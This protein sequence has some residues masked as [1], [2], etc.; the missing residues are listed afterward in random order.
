MTGTNA[1]VEKVLVLDPSRWQGKN[2]HVIHLLL[3]EN[4]NEIRNDFWF[5]SSFTWECRSSWALL[6]HRKYKVKVVMRV[7]ATDKCQGEHLLA[8]LKLVKKLIALFCVFFCFCFAERLFSGWFVSAHQSLVGT[9]YGGQRSS[10][11]FCGAIIPPNQSGWI[12]SQTTWKRVIHSICPPPTIK[13]ERRKSPLTINTHWY[14]YISFSTSFS[15][16]FEGSVDDTV[17]IRVDGSPII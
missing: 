11:C 13:S 17:S 14:A 16:E 3:W 8:Y 15:F 4:D 9:V 5:F 2:L 7:P 6:S 12:S 1:T 10:Q